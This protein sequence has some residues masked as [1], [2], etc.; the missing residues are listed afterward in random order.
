M[1][2]DIREIKEMNYKK[3]IDGEPELSFL[4][5][6]YGKNLSKLYGMVCVHM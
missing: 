1:E 2:T 4:M 5:M 6:Q 3:E